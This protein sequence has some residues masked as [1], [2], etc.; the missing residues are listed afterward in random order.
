[1]YECTTDCMQMCT[2]Q[3]CNSDTGVSH[4]A[5]NDYLIIVIYV[6]MQYKIMGVVV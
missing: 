3:E 1:M 5:M 6:Y 2:F 4:D